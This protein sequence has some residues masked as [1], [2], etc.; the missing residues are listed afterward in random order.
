[1]TQSVFYVETTVILVFGMPGG[2]SHIKVVTHRY[3]PQV[4]IQDYI[5]NVLLLKKLYILGRSV[6]VKL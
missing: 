3:V 5:W 2:A 6:N 4:T 1:M